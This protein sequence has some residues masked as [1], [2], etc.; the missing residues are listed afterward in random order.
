MDFETQFRRYY[1]AIYRFAYRIVQNEEDARDIT[2]ETFGKLL[3][4]MRQER[5]PENVR[6]W[7]YRVAANGSYNLVERTGRRAELRAQQFET[8]AGT[9]DP[10][11]QM[12]RLEQTQRM[13]NSIEALNHKDQ[14]ML[15]LYH[16]GFS[17]REMAEVLEINPNSVGKILA[18][19]VE[20]VRIQMNEE[21]R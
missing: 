16:D 5:T 9:R 20:K 8:P 2:Q 17:Y 14:T 11:D 19:A 18:R 13:W 10:A 15:M 7:L 1:R 6:A 3:E 21:S 12:E 4:T